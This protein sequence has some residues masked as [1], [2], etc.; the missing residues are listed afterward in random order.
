[1]YCDSASLSNVY[2]L[3]VDFG[4]EVIAYQIP[5]EITFSHFNEGSVGKDFN[6][7]Y[8]VY[9]NFRQFPRIFSEL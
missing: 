4:K 5:E 6:V 9:R 2:S 7:W 3:N 1:M 8:F